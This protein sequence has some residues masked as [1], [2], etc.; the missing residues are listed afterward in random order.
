MF[1]RRNL[2]ASCLSSA[3]SGVVSAAGKFHEGIAIDDEKQLISATNPDGYSLY[4][5]SKRLRDD[6]DVVLAA[7]QKDGM[8]LQSASESLRADETVVPHAINQNPSAERYSKV[9]TFGQLFE[10][11]ATCTAGLLLSGLMFY[12]LSYQQQRASYSYHKK[13]EKLLILPT[14]A[15]MAVSTVVLANTTSRVAEKSWRAISPI[16][17]ATDDRGSDDVEDEDLVSASQALG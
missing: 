17:T 6:R 14:M 3:A 11:A 9:E 7:L 12:G 10:R 5:A 1:Y 13:D 15:L 16:F 2:L 8:A 4:M